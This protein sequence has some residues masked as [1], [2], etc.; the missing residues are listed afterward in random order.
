MLV[1]Q[2]LYST[3]RLTFG[4]YADLGNEARSTS[5]VKSMLRLSNSIA[6]IGIGI[7]ALLAVVLALTSNPGW[8]IGFLANACGFSLALFLARD[9]RLQLS[10]QC[11]VLSMNLLMLTIAA[12]AGVSNS[13]SMLLPLIIL[14][15]MILLRDHSKRCLQTYF[16]LALVA[17]GLGN[18]LHNYLPSMALLNFAADTYLASYLGLAITIGIFLAG[19]QLIHDVDLARRQVERVN[20]DRDTLIGIISH[21]INNNLQIIQG[22][23]KLIERDHSIA[24]SAQ[25]KRYYGRAMRSFDHLLDVMEQIRGLRHLGQLHIPINK[26]PIDFNE[27]MDYVG[28]VFADKFDAKGIQLICSNNLPDNKKI[29]ADQT[30]FFHSILINLVSNACKYSHPGGTIKV[31][32]TASD[33]HFAM[34]TVEDHGIGMDIEDQ[35]E[36]FIGDPVASKHGTTG[37][38]LGT[39]IGLRVA[40]MQVHLHGGRMFV[41]STPGK[42]TILT[43]QMPLIEVDATNQHQDADIKTA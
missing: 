31:A 17:F 39:G 29:L 36:L 40:R 34:I 37:E 38:P 9:E 3:L 23:L 1:F 43:I 30:S 13:T 26:E 11:C 15:P 12:G 19:I 22:C 10:R 16:V 35:Q 33:A 20:I 2:R 27:A 6:L 25:G 41:D 18:S 4:I 7:S 8:A 5:A 21:D 28:F 32:V 24:N 14:L 42:G